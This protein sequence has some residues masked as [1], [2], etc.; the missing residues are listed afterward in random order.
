MEC[1]VEESVGIGTEVSPAAGDAFRLVR[2][3]HE[4]EGSEENGDGEVNDEEGDED[5]GETCVEGPID[6]VIHEV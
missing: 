2:A 5:F 1:V 6:V 4:E 3:G